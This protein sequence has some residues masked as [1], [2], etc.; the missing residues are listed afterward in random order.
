MLDFQTKDGTKRTTAVAI[1]GTRV[2]AAIVRGKMIKI[3]HDQILRNECDLGEG[4]FVSMNE[5]H[6]EKVKPATSF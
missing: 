1:F 2:D 6:T 3:C 4:I 5:L